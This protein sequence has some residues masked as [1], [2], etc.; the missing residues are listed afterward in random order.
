MQSDDDSRDAVLWRTTL[1]PSRADS[2]RYII[3]PLVFKF[4][5]PRKKINLVSSTCF[6][7]VCTRIVSFALLSAGANST[8][9]ALWY[10][11]WLALNI[12]PP[13]FFSPNPFVYFCSHFDLWDWGGRSNTSGA[14]KVCRT[15]LRVTANSLLF[16]FS[17]RC[18][19]IELWKAQ[20]RLHCL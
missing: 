8:W 9:M 10:I 11:S 12:F 2:C 6:N 18:H 14:V 20:I 13:S 15:K 5:T 19:N 3:Y 4:Y 17:S 7:S 1:H 16:H